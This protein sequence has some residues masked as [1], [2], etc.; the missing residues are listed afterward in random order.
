V[1]IYINIYIYTV[2]IRLYW[3]LFHLQSVE[4]VLTSYHPMSTS[5]WL[6]VSRDIIH[7]SGDPTSLGALVLSTW[8]TIAVL[9]ARGQSSARWHHHQSLSPF[10]DIMKAL[11]VS[12]QPQQQCVPPLLHTWTP[13]FKELRTE[14]SCSPATHGTVTDIL[15]TLYCSYHRKGAWRESLTQSTACSFIHSHTPWTIKNPGVTQGHAPFTHG[16]L[17]N[18]TNDNHI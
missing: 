3:S 7:I 11:Q 12:W 14:D 10:T 1:Y 8:S 18:T 9:A 15:D 16:A 17:I 13:S 2:Y 6:S 5:D 4:R